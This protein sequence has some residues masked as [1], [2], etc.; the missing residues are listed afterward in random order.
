MSI[1]ASLRTIVRHY[2]V[3]DQLD[4]K[5][6]DCVLPFL[7]LLIKMVKKKGKRKTAETEEQKQLRW[8]MKAI[9]EE[10]MRKKRQEQQRAKLEVARF[11]RIS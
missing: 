9:K 10:E 8:E 7:G 4:F 11:R 6:K 2:R 3:E 5:L 1:S